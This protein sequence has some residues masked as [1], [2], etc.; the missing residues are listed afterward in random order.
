[1]E[2]RKVLVRFQ[3][4]DG[5]DQFYSSQN[6]TR[7][8]TCG[9]I[10]HQTGPNW[11]KSGQALFISPVIRQFLFLVSLLSA[12]HR[13]TKSKELHKVSRFKGANHC[14]SLADSVG[15]G[16]TLKSELHPLD[17]ANFFLKI[18]KYYAVY[19]E[20]TKAEKKK[21]CVLVFVLNIKSRV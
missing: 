17:V 3:R 8:C 9:A 4:A 18:S 5:R 21:L 19:L 10:I 16:N 15:G 12:L 11:L 2:S 7:V 20:V 6:N 14:S 13:R 1:M